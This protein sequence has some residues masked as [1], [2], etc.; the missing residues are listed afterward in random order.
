LLFTISERNNYVFSTTSRFRV[1]SFNK[2]PHLFPFSRKQHP[3]T[4]CYYCFSH[5]CIV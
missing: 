5:T 3:R 2:S 1:K 4:D